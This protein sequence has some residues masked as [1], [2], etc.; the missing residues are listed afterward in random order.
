MFYPA[1]LLAQTPSKAETDYL[2]GLF[3][4]YRF[5]SNI[6]KA[7]NP[8]LAQL[9]DSLEQYA[10][11]FIQHGGPEGRML[12]LQCELP[13]IWAFSRENHPLDSMTAT[14]FMRSL[15]ASHLAGI[16][17]LLDSPQK[18][19]VDLL[20]LQQLGFQPYAVAGDSHSAA[21]TIPFLVTRGLLPL[22]FLCTGGSARGLTNSNSRSGY[23][24]RLLGAMSR[25]NECSRRTAVIL[26]FGQVDMEFVVYYSTI[27]ETRRNSISRSEIT[28]FARETTARYFSFVQELK[29]FSNIQPCIAT[30]FPPC[31]SDRTVHNGYVNAHIAFLHASLPVE[32]L[33]ERVLSFEFP[34]LAERTC[35]H[36]EFNGYLERYSRETSSLVLDVSS[37]LRDRS[38][39]AADIF[40]HE[41]KGSDHHLHCNAFSEITLQALYS[42][43]GVH[44]TNIKSGVL[45]GGDIKVGTIKRFLKR[46]NEF[47]LKGR[48][49]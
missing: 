4:R 28:E 10:R 23:R 49:G 1:S 21:Y 44:D 47:L 39:L 34:M 40:I 22:W 17:S 26:C 20:D 42:M 8:D 37:K 27:T 11:H 30:I 41:P 6:Y 12:S 24:E 45:Q 32:E 36:D 35:I 46:A 5:D 25:L 2:C 33:R 48:T 9:G 31:L 15:V 3:E 14:Y 16:G 13:E 29:T 18:V 38:G 43:L 7:T 19:L